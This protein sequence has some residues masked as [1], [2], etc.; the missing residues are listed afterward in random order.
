MAGSYVYLLAMVASL[1]ATWLVLFML[2]HLVTGPLAWICPSDD[3]SDHVEGSD[4]DVEDPD[5]FFERA[6]YGD[7]DIIDDSDTDAE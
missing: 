5:D 2:Y 3:P 4:S 1:V 6:V 7:V